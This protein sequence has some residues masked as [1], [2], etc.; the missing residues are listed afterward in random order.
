MSYKDFGTDFIKLLVKIMKK[1]SFDD[2]CQCSQ[3]NK[4]N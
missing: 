1:G 4:N 2:L 3:L